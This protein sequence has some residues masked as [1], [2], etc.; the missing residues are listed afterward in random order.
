[1][2]AKKQYESR[3]K[4]HDFILISAF[5]VLLLSLIICCLGIR[6]CHIVGLSMLPSVFHK[7]KMIAIEQFEIKRFDIVAVVFDGDYLCKRV[8]GVPGDTM[9][10]T[11]NSIIINGQ[12]LSERYILEIPYY[13]EQTVKLGKSQYFVMGDNRNSSHDSRVFGPV[14]RRNINGKLVY[15]IWRH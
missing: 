7:D 2:F 3:R 12:L 8:V 4:T 9:I 6:P 14:S 11:K 10:F 13:K 1:M 5:I 15:R